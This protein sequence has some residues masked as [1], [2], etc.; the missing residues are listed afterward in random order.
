MNYYQIETVVCGMYAINVTGQLPQYIR[1]E[2]ESRH[3]VVPENF[4]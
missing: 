4:D 3:M 1:E 2:L